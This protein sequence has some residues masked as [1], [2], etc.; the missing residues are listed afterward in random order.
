MRDASDHALLDQPDCWPALP[1]G[2]WKETL[3][4]LHMWTQIVGKVR[5]ALEP[6]VNHWW[7]VPSVRRGRRPPLL[8]RARRDRPRAQ[9]VPSR[10]R[11]QSE[12][13][14]LFLGRV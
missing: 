8:A 5:L 14:P 10:S 2:D 1:L 6:M 7:Q 4:T 9:T 13:G 11:R 12:P 3:A